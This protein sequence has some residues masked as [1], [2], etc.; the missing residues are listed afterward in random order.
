MALSLKK[1]T[2]FLVSGTFNGANLSKKLRGTAETENVSKVY[3]QKSQWMS[4]ATVGMANPWMYF[5][6][7][8]F[9]LGK[10][11]TSLIGAQL[12]YVVFW[13]PPT[14]A[15]DFKVQLG[16]GA[17]AGSSYQKQWTSI[18]PGTFLIT[19]SDLPTLQGGAP[20][21]RVQPNPD[22]EELIETEVNNLHFMVVS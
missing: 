5:D 19:E 13:S 15:R 18:E 6:L 22:A 14:N 16:T 12:L 10:T 21:L 9:R 17:T 2:E 1:M 8:Y 20:Y 11:Q 4:G 7:S 3:V